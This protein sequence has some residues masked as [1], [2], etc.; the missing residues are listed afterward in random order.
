ML[1][2]ELE[3]LE[4]LHLWRTLKLSPGLVEFLYAAR[5][6]VSVLCTNFHPDFSKITVVQTNESKLKERDPFLAFT[7]L[8]VE[9]TSHVLAEGQDGAVFRCAA[10][11]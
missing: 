6:H 10:A 1:L 8:M 2:A 4:D 5:Y 9:S 7:R 11:Q 3:A